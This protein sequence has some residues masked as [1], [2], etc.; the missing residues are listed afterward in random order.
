[1]DN[2][3]L[4]EAGYDSYLT[5]WVYQQS[6]RFYENV[7][8]ECKN[9]LNINNSFFFVNLSTMEDEVNPYVVILIFSML[10]ISS[11]SIFS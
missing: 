7:S 5:A 10:K 9:R 8:A 2:Q 3:I 1:M 4:H 11:D 6:M